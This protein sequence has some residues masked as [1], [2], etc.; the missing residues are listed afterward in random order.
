MT[1]GDF[2]FGR[3]VA[4]YSNRRSSTVRTPCDGTLAL[5]IG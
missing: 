2:V 5:R 3:I 1:R 4:L